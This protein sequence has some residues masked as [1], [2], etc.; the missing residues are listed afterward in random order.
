MSMMHDTDNAIVARKAD[1]N[2]EGKGL[3]GLLLDLRRS[4][5]RGVVAKSHRQVLAE[6]FTSMLVL[7][8]TFRYR[9]ATG[10][11]N[12]LYWHAGE[13]SLSLIAP[14]EWSDERRAGFVGTCELQQ[15]MTWTIAPSARLIE[16]GNPVSDAVAHFYD[17]FA[18][19]LDT[20]LPLEEILPFHAGDLAYYPRLYAH[21]LSRSVVTAVTLGGQASTSSRQWSSLLPR[22]ESLLLACGS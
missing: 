12:F 4:E 15:D 14:G 1:G 21:A 13:W 2:P 6:L 7:S 11:P 16:G 19:L 8:A 10:T 3:N 17:G 20:D 22:Q 9:P 5:P 18:E